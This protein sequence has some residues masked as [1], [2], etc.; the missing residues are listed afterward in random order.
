MATTE[1]GDGQSNG[2]A[3]VKAGDQPAG[4][5]Q[6]LQQILVSRESEIKRLVGTV[7]S[8]ERLTSLALLAVGGSELLSQCSLSSVVKGVLDAARMGL[9]IDGVHAALVPMWSG[10]LKRYE[11]QCWPMARGLIARAYDDPSVQEVTARCVYDGELFDVRYGTNDSIE[12]VP[13]A[14]AIAVGKDAIVAAYAVIHMRGRAKFE[15]MFRSQIDAIMARSPSVRSKKFSPWE[16]D[17]EQMAQKTVVKRLTKTAPLKSQRLFAALATDA[18]NDAADVIDVTDD[19]PP[20]DPPKRAKRTDELKQKMT[21]HAAP[22]PEDEPKKPDAVEP[23]KQAM[24]TD[25]QKTKIRSMCDR[26]GAKKTGEV[27]TMVAGVLALK[28]LES[29]SDLTAK[30]AEIAID[31][32]SGAKAMRDAEAKAAA[33]GE[34]DPSLGNNR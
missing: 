5:R 1:Q 6:A 14:N 16:S 15:V 20:A 21:Q 32:I 11:A 17:Y 13:D 25:E 9:E 30:Q 23:P 2:A 18:E 26:G 4:N 34:A 8:A 7:M 27:L 19:A 22:P 31:I 33:A 10:K 3:I 29:L 12:H 28:D 24:I